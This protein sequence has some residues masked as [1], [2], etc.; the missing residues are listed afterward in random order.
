[1]FTPLPRRATHLV[2]V[3]FC[4]SL[5]SVG[6]GFAAGENVPK[7]A[8]VSIELNAL[9]EQSGACRISFLVE[10]RYGEDIGQAVY[11]TVLFNP[12]GQVARLTLFDFQSLPSQRPRVRQF[13]IDGLACN[14][15]GRILI[16]G[17]DT[18]TGDGL[19]PNA[20]QDGLDLKSV[21]MVELVG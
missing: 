18:C 11:E 16:N 13:Q 2:L 1:M 8:G 19:P 6:S 9:D 17:A 7:P 10:N 14:D 5:M 21:T 20:C 15:I 12:Q 4:A 3:F